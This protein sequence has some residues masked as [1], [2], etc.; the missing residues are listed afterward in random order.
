[1]NN[2][3]VGGKTSYRLGKLES[4]P[5]FFLRATTYFINRKSSYMTKQMW[6]RKDRPGENSCPK[7]FAE[8]TLKDRKIQN[9]P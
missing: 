6:K 5:T 4:V 2:L 9:D 8:R 1:M 7:I 3:G